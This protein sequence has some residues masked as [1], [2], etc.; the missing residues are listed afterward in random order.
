MALLQV[1]QL[2]HLA[3]DQQLVRAHL[4]LTARR[5]EQQ[6]IH[7]TDGRLVFRIY[8][9]ESR[10]KALVATQLESIAEARR[11]A[12]VEAVLKDGLTTGE[13]ALFVANLF[14]VKTLQMLC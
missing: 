8:L 7:R 5:L 11:V 12:V 3:I 13:G 10:C 1:Q 14:D 9:V 4:A 6:K 2:F